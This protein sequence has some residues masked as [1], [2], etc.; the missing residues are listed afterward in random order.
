VTW[1]EALEGRRLLSAA[2]APDV[3]P[4]P[5]AAVAAGEAV[6]IDGD[7][8]PGHSPGVATFDGDVAF[9]ATARLEIEL[10]GTTPG[11]EYD[12]VNVG[13]RATL[14]GTLHVVLLGSFIPQAGD[15]FRVLT[16]GSRAGDFDHYVGLDLPNGLRLRPVFTADALTLTALPPAQVVARHV[17][18]NGCAFD[19]HDPA[20]NAADD[21]A[22]APGKEALRG[23]A[24]PSFANVT[25]YSR[26]ING[27]MVDVLNLGGVASADDF[28]LRVST[29]LPAASWSAA[30][31]PA[32]IAVRPGAGVGGSDR[33]TL[34]WPDGAIRNRWLQVTLRPTLSNGLPAPDVFAFGNLIG[35]TD[36]ALTPLRVGAADVVA[37]RSAIPRSGASIDSPYDHDRDG[38]VN[39][40]DLAAARANLGR[41]L[42]PPP[43]TPAAASLARATRARRDRPVARAIW[44]V[45]LLSGS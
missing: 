37:T 18:Y 36:D 14:G 15:R 6:V 41:S 33:V 7:L 2:A 39:A 42:P 25:A 24:A 10:A 12:V 22:I 3:A 40:R 27:V 35:E 38:R 28:L 17:F 34:T 19:N 4:V 26:G 1:F 8:R 21:A 5:F 32:S 30:P 44:A 11:T 31:V 45:S 20:A 29:D 9:S 43:A 13:G 16:Y 23:A